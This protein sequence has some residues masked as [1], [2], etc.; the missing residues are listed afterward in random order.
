MSGFLFFIMYFIIIYKEPVENL[1]K[2]PL[3]HFGGEGGIVQRR[4]RIARN[5]L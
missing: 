1:S 5:R 4:I 3:G 2:V